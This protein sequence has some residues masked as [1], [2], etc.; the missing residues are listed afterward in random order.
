MDHGSTATDVLDRNMLDEVAAG[1]LELIRELAELY[2]DDAEAQLVALDEA[3]AAGDLPAVGRVAHGL[4]GSSA[5]LG[6]GEA[7]EAFRQLEELGRN[8]QSEGLADAVT[9]GHEAFERVR[10]VLTAI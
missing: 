2:I 10:A 6:A 4:K 7:A 1:D 5:S 9:H 8:G 3:V